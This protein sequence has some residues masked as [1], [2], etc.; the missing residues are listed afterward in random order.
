MNTTVDVLVAVAVALWLLVVAVLGGFFQLD[1]D[2][3]L[4]DTPG[5]D[6]IPL[7]SLMVLGG[8]LAGLLIALLVRFPVAVAARRRGA[9]V[10]NKLLKR[11]GVI[12]DETVLADIGRVLAERNEIADQLA[13]A[14]A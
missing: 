8:L 13:I 1:T 12:A 6:W 4:I 14:T 7:P 10:R 5:W 3:L 9:R 11:V 2:P